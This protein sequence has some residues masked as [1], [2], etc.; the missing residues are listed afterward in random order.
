MVLIWLLL[1]FVVG[2]AHFGPRLTGLI[3]GVWTWPC[4]RFLP[5][6]CLWKSTSW[7]I[8]SYLGLVGTCVCHPNTREWL[9]TGVGGF[10][11][12]SLLMSSFICPILSLGR[13]AHPLWHFLFLRRIAWIIF[14]VVLNLDLLWG[15]L[16]RCLFLALFL[17]VGRQCHFS[18]SSHNALMSFIRVT[19]T[20]HGVDTP[21]ESLKKQGKGIPRWRPI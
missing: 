20:I 14:H 1:Q 8:F 16:E 13:Q 2:S 19:C 7:P 21:A 4:L 18:D 3:W 9:A 10:H 17:F 5:R 11:S 15:L 12:H 6:C